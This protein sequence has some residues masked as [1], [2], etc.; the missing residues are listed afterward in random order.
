MS[1]K[2]I[3]DVQLDFS[4]LKGGN[5]SKIPVAYESLIDFRDVQ[6]KWIRIANLQN[7]PFNC[8]LH[9]RHSYLSSGVSCP[10]LLH[11]AGNAQNYDL[12]GF[13]MNISNL[14]SNQKNIAKSFDKIRITME[15]GEKFLEIHFLRNDGPIQI[16][17]VFSHCYFVTPVN[18]YLVEE[19]TEASKEEIIPDFL[20]KHAYLN[21]LLNTD[22][23]QLTDNQSLMG[24]V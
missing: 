16:Q 14:S 9:I 23:M 5:A 20:D 2:N 4:N 22:N 15:N 12:N 17:T 10:L 24:G 18:P 19:N 8:V 7:Y 3:K 21:D 11:I 1:R 13:F 6:S